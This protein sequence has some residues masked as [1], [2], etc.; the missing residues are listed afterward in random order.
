MRAGLN[1]PMA[2]QNQKSLVLAL[3][4]RLSQEVQAPA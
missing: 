2:S 3:L 4:S 1:T